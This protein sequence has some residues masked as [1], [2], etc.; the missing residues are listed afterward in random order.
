MPKGPPAPT[1]KDVRLG[2]LSWARQ[3]RGVVA[4]ASFHANGFVREVAVRLLS[5]LHDGSELPYLLIRT[6]DWV[7]KIQVAAASAALKRVTSAYTQHWVRSL[8]LLDRLRASQRRERGSAL[9][10]R[11]VEA[12][13][14][15][16]DARTALESALSTAEAELPI[17]RA[18]LRLALL[19]PSAEHRPLLQI[20]VRDP[21]PLIAFDA[22]KGLLQ[23]ATPDVSAVVHLLD[24]RIGRIRNLALAAA[25]EHHAPSALDAL[26]RAVFDDARCVR[27]LARHELS[28]LS[29][30]PRD[31]RTMYR[32][33]VWECHGSARRIALEGLAETG[34]RDDVE[35]FLGFL[36]DQDARARAAAIAGLG[37]C[38][39]ENHHDE[40]VAALVD[41]SSAVRKAAA[42]FARL[43]LGRGPVQQVQRALRERA[44]RAGKLDPPLATVAKR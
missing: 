38:D 43:H 3:Y 42:P 26:E 19:L 44:S 12:L 25:L 36:Q 37:R 28:R 29:R 13:L 17:R 33:R 10:V 27:E 2:S 32:Q 35:L 5:E 18:A 7:P 16:K 23:N 34:T 9:Y 20:A 6:N 21:D 11:R 24:H 30:A 4:L 39:G 15:H 8:G 31:F 1:W 14:L 41:R 40:L 22:A